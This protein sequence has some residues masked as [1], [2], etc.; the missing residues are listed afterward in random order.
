MMRL[1]G[2]CMSNENV[3]PQLIQLFHSIRSRFFFP[4]LPLDEIAHWNKQQVDGLR[5]GRC[6]G[7]REDRR[8]TISSLLV[9]LP[10][11]CSHHYLTTTCVVRPT[12]TKWA[13]Q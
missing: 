7:G 5:T 4:E 1:C 3:R 11:S 8:N 9:Q 13:P 10:F 12:T 6:Q 2:E